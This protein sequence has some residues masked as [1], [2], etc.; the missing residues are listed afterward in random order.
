MAAGFAE[1]GFGV[2]VAVG[3][4]EIFSVGGGGFEATGA[5]GGFVGLGVTTGGGPIVGRGRFQENKHV[6]F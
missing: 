2:G 3:L 4:I 5:T 1:L 6:R